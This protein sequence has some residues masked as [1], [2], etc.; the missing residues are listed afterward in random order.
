[1]YAGRMRKGTEMNDYMRMFVDGVKK[2]CPIYLLTQVVCT[3]KLAMVSC[4]SPGCSMRIFI[5][6]LIVSN[7]IMRKE[8][9]PPNVP[10]TYWYLL[11]S[12]QLSFE[13]Q[14]LSFIILCLQEVCRKFNSQN[15]A[16][17]AGRQGNNSD[18]LTF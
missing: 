5:A 6:I 2:L 1:M 11:S 4:A 13:V 17:A 14:I 9:Y 10:T 3:V 7:E 15:Q 16:K 8:R 18:I 12:K